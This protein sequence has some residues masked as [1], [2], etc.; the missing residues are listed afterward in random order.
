MM[1]FRILTQAL[2]AVF[3]VFGA[4]HSGYANTPLD[5]LAASMTPGTWA[6]LPQ[7]NINAVLGQGSISGN[8][9]PFAMTAAWDPSRQILHFVGNDH[10]DSA[11]HYIYY[12]AAT[13][14]WTFAGNLPMPASHGYDHLSLDPN[15]GIL[16]F[17]QYGLTNI[18]QYPPGGSW[19]LQTSWN[20][21]QYVQIAIGTAWWRG[22]L[23]GAGANG[24]LIVYNCGAINGEVLVWDP[25][26]NNWFADITGFGGTST[27]HCF[28]E[29][30]PV[31]NVAIFGGGNDSPRKLWRLNPDRSITAMPDA[32]VDLGIQKANVTVDPVTGNFLI[33]GFGQLW[34]FDPRGVG[35]W[36]NQS[37]SRIPPS[38]VGNPGTPNFDSVISAPISGD[39]VVSY[40]TCRATNCNMYLYKHAAAGAVSPAP[41]AD[42]SFQ[43]LCDPNANPGVAKCV[44]FDSTADL[45]GNYGDI[46]GTL[47]DAYGA[48]RPQIDFTVKA[49]GAGS[50][51]F[52]IPPTSGPD[53]SGEYFT[54]FSNDLSTQFGEKSNFYIQWRQ[55]FSPEFANT[56][57]AGGEGWKQ[58]ILGTGDQPG[59]NGAGGN[60]PCYSSCSDLEIVTFNGFHRGFAQMYNSC[61]GSTSHGPFDPFE[62]PFNNDIKLQNA[63]PSPYCLYSQR[64]NNPPFSGG[65]CFRYF[66]NEWMTF[67]LHIKTGPR[68]NDEFTNSFV[69]LWI[70][71]EGQPAELAFDWGPYNLSAGNPLSNEKFGKVWLTPYNTNK[72]PS[73]AYPLAYTWY[74]ELI[75]SAQ[76]IPIRSSVTSFVVNTGPTISNVAVT[77]ISNTTA[78]IT[79]TTSTPSTS[80]VQYGTTVS[81]GSQTSLDTTPVTSHLQTITGLIPGSGYNYQVQSRDGTGI[82]SLSSNALFT[83][84]NSPLSSGSLNNGLLAD[85][86][87]EEG[88]G[89][90]T[91]D[92]SGHGYTGT[93]SNNNGPLLPVWA[94]GR[95]GSAL[96]FDATDNDG[97]DNDDPR[98]VVGRSLDVSS[99]P[100]SIS[101]WVNPQDFTDYRAI[102]S[103]RDLND[104]TRMR[105]DWGLN[106]SNGGV[107]LRQRG[108][109]I[110]FS[111]SPPRNVWTH[112]AVVADSTV[113]R[114]YVNGILREIKGPFTLG[115]GSNANVVIGGT[116]EPVGGDNDPYKGMIDAL[117]VYTRAL[118]SN[119]VQQVYAFAG[120]SITN[121]SVS[122]ITNT[123]ATITWTTDELADSQVQYGTTSA[124]GQTTTLNPSLITNHSVTLTLLSASTT[125]HFSVKSRD[126]GGTSASIPDAIFATT[127][128]PVVVLSPSTLPDGITGVAYSQTIT[129]SGGF[130]PYSFSISAGA[131]PGG[132]SLNGTNGLISGPPNVLGSSTFTVHVVDSAGNTANRQYTINISNVVSDN[133]FLNLVGRNWDSA[134]FPEFVGRLTLN[135]T[136]TNAGP[137]ITSSLVLQL[138]DLHKLFPDQAPDH[139][140]VLLSADN[141]FGTVGD[142]QTLSINSLGTNQYAQFSI[143][144]GI[145]SRQTFVIE[146]TLK[147]GASGSPSTAA[148][149]S[150][151]ALAVSVPSAGTVIGG[152]KLT[153]SEA[154]LD[155]ITA[156]DRSGPA[157]TL[158]PVPNVGVL[159]NV[160]IITGSGAQSRPSVAV[161]P[162]TQTHMAVASND[163]AARAIRVSTSWDGGQTWQSAT[164][165]QSI[166]GQS[167]FSAQ[168]P[169]LTFDSQGKLSAV[170]TL[171]NLN[172]SANAIVLSESVDGI[173]FTP[174]T[175]ITFNSASSALID[176]R[177]VIAIKSGAGRYIAWDRVSTVNFRYGINIVR[178]DEGGAFGSVT[179]VVT[180]SLVSSPVVA[181]GKSSVYVGWDEWR[182]NSTSPY[183][184]GGRLMIASSPS[185]SSLNFG[186]PQEIAR[187]SIGFGQRI[188][189][190]PDVGVGPDLGLAVDPSEDRLVHAVFADRGN[191]MDI[192]YARST[193]SGN[194]WQT[195]TVNNDT[196]LADQFTP[197]I[198]LDTDSDL[199][200]IFYDTHLS[201]TFQAADVFLARP[202]SGSLF[203]NQRIT[204]SSSN[205]SRQNPTRNFS[206]DLGDRLSISQTAGYML[207]AWT[208]T[209]LGN[210]DVFAS[211]IAR[212]A[213]SA[214]PNIS[215][216]P[217]PITY[218]AVLGS[219][220]LNASAPTQGTFVYSPPAGTVLNAGTQTLSLKFMPSDTLHFSQASMNVQINVAPAPLTITANPVSRSYGFP[221]PTLSGSIVGLVNGDNITAT[222]TTTATVSSTVGSYVITPVMS[223]PDARLSNYS[224][225]GGAGRINGTLTVTPAPL[226]LIVDS[227]ARVYGSPNPPFTATLSGL[228]NGD[229]ISATYTTTATISSIVGNYAIT[230][231]I[232]DPDGR[233]ANY[234]INGGAGAV[235]GAP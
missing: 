50:M 54:N 30:S 93:L 217:G 197:A 60:G 84:D 14:S 31:Y 220:Q 205:D 226:K 228:V 232:N 229:K 150:L 40:V 221:N 1:K 149:G 169:S 184:T 27:Y 158:S 100:F 207:M 164:L 170:Y 105:F 52:T 107:Y 196:S 192:R 203:D 122:N 145:G 141:G 101:G 116:G 72:D 66:S 22:A 75:I 124:Y 2:S 222:F 167:F 61:S 121:I 99:L 65:N 23:N 59:C 201:S 26:A 188:P 103:K 15:T 63:R 189:A 138:T 45:G 132:V 176:S 19:S 215:W 67:Q 148:D 162:I 175:A 62:Q 32:P 146:V 131:L 211:M 223:D 48:L 118:S 51:Q 29:Y 4:L 25:L 117:R 91:A 120:P 96:R 17:R 69:Q 21:T 85:W 82:L 35:R 97:N 71:R 193:D 47:P 199:Y 143:L 160:G 129:A 127:A 225:N 8:Q 64:L 53:S 202:S 76:P 70:A 168:D 108:T 106:L 191:G 218:G 194:T 171:S 210:E 147:T 3:F 152:L 77:D 79:W 55:R 214:L 113:T 46:S 88:T 178:S 37:G 212:P 98:V 213:P 39:G 157:R 134:P 94:T 208:D 177:P 68:V 95:V 156:P 73:V 87:F 80:Q 90:T 119:D 130:T 163:Y 231:V 11:T 102:F 18:W 89:L 42:Y 7:T 44:G 58:F 92:T 174:P 16:Y 151:K 181:L 227:L 140:N 209:R 185:G 173:N 110:D 233:L 133:V 182:F 123:G 115:T 78:T 57:Y 206:A 142:V 187:T 33:M 153:V 216:N 195:G 49:S 41:P 126:A 136:L 24:A 180:D 128:T 109:S 204:T 114:L 5:D 38:A 125:Y 166:L 10:N 219:D 190:M 235:N 111:Y 198:A 9:L 135:F 56:V 165:S 200:I 144:I 230:P 155:E 161:D 137:P 83:T 36:T 179:P 104:A 81:Y 172:D 74:D 186:S 13:N 28:T 12:T 154:T 159:N 20:S 86:R 43:S 139:P 234:S 183:R 34:E 112:L 6:Q 224:L